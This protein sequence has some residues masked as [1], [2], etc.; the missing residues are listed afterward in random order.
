MVLRIINTKTHD[1]L[2]D[3]IEALMTGE[4]LFW[5]S[6]VLMILPDCVLNFVYVRPFA[7]SVFPVGKV[8]PPHP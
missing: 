8:Y 2:A 4:I 7:N 1:T 3:M 5:N 6:F